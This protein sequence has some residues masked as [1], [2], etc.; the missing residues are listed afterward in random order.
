MKRGNYT[1]EAKSKKE[2]KNKAIKLHVKKT[3]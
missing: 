2:A 3:R 1:V